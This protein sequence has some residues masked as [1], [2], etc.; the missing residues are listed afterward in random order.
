[1]ITYTLKHLHQDIKQHLFH[2]CRRMEWNPHYFQE[3]KKYISA[4]MANLNKL[5]NQGDN[6]SFAV[7]FNDLMQTDNKGRKKFNRHRFLHL[8]QTN[9][10]LEYNQQLKTMH[11]TEPAKK[12]NSFTKG[13]GGYCFTSPD[14]K[15]TIIVY[16]ISTLN[17]TEALAVPYHEYGHALDFK[18]SLLDSTEAYHNFRLYAKE[19]RKNANDN[20]LKTQANQ[21]C[22]E[23]HMLQESFADCFAYSCLAL[24]E[25]HNPVVYRKGF[26]NMAVKFC[27]VVEN[28]HNSLY[29]GYAATRTMLNKIQL[30]YRCQNMD[31]YYLSDGSIDFLTLAHTCA[32]VIKEQ[33]YNHDNYQTLTTYPLQNMSAGQHLKPQQYDQWHYDYLEAKN[34][35]QKNR[36]TNPV[37]RLLYGV[38]QEILQTSDKLKLLNLLNKYEIPAL[39]ACFQEYRYLINQQ[40]VREHPATISQLLKQQKNRK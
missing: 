32:N 9:F 8:C 30:D 28:K 33:G 4:D 34:A 24:K 39:S 22:S 16:A 19:Y 12:F 29:C 18:Y 11:L 7:C 13:Q 17:V 40:I 10:G 38:G 25:P 3:L 20:N 5:C 15:K 31:K 26:Y 2:G 14:F 27:N 6:Q 23:W 1:M 35:I 36:I 37:Y 21:Y